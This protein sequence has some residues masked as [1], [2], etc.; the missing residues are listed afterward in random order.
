VCAY[1][2]GS[3]VTY[4]STAGAAEESHI[5]HEFTACISA[6]IQLHL[7]YWEVSICQPS[8]YKHALH[9]LKSLL[10]TQ[11]SLFNISMGSEQRLFD[12]TIQRTEEFNN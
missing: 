12:T 3:F 2:G 4:L 9:I 7:L 6:T 8:A 11:Y 10:N 1:T 5:C